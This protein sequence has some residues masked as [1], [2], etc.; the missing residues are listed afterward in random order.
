MAN[1]HFH[2]FIYTILLFAV[3]FWCASFLSV[4]FLKSGEPWPRFLEVLIR[5]FFAPVCHQNPV[6]SFHVMGKPLA[7]CARC[8]GIY[9][10]FWLGVVVYPLFFRFKSEIS[11][12]RNILILS[13]TPMGVDV[14]VEWAGLFASP[15]WVHAFT[16]FIAGYVVAFIVVPGLFSAASWFY[17]KRSRHGSIF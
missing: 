17:E 3:T 16:G 12:S 14:F 4:P 8:S 5:Q 11:V 9:I 6:R 13:L 15:N 7:V 1:K 10:G 2:V